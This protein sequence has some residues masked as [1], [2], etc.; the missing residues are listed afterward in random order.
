MRKYFLLSALALMISGTANATTDY[1]EVTAKS[2]IEVATVK[3]PI[4]CL[5][6]IYLSVHISRM[7]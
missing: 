4:Y 7:W 1:A 2:T 5:P 6:T 3:A